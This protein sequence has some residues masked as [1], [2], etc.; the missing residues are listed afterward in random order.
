[1]DWVCPI[2]VD[3]V[4]ARLLTRSW[5]KLYETMNYKTPLHMWLTITNVSSQIL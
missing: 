4:W 5:L 1:M 2:V 3:G